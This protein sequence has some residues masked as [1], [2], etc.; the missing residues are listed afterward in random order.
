[1]GNR[2]FERALDPLGARRK[3]RARSVPAPSFFFWPRPAPAAAPRSL[4]RLSLSRSRRVVCARAFQAGCIHGPAPT[5]LGSGA[6]AAGSRV[7]GPRAGARVLVSDP[8]AI[9]RGSEPPISAGAAARLLPCPSERAFRPSLPC[10]F[11]WPSAPGA[12]NGWPIPRMRA[13]R[14]GESA[15]ERRRVSLFFPPSS[16]PCSR[17]P[18][19]RR[20]L[21]SRPAH[22]RPRPPPPPPPPPSLP[23]PQEADTIR[24]RRAA[25]AAGG[26]Y[27]DPEAKV[28]LAIRIRG[29]NDMAPKSRK[30]LQL[31]RLR[32]IHNAVFI[33]VG[34]GNEMSAERA[35]SS[36][37]GR[38]SLFSL[39]PITHTPPPS[40]SLPLPSPTPHTRRSTRPP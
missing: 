26:F 34:G 38:E 11:P 30:I 33:K 22:S 17:R 19:P 9:A 29:I 20:S 13:G 37:R 8:L 3:G 15:G 1:M 18:P 28:V 24:L 23:R 21:S 36:E 5:R 2:A 6:A 40:L 7:C 31:L 14:R 4:S 25:K 12:V 27:T 10:P 16:P 35:E 32:Q 39:P